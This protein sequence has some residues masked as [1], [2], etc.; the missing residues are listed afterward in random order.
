[1][2]VIILIP[3]DKQLLRFS[4]LLDQVTEIMYHLFKSVQFDFDEGNLRSGSGNKLLLSFAM[5][6]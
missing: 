4:S 3:L 2:N 5:A 6:K 1:M